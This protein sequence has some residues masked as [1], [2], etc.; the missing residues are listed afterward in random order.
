MLAISP[1]SEALAKMLQEKQ[2]ERL[3]LEADVKKMT[4]EHQQMEGLKGQ[5][6]AQ[7]A[8]LKVNIRETLARCLSLEQQLENA[9]RY[10]SENVERAVQEAE[11][12]EAVATP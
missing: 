2:D 8:A 12:Q 4:Y 6:E 9:Q 5:V 10:I 11:V 3:K 7:L 1:A